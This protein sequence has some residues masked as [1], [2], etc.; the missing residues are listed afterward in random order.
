MKELHQSAVSKQ[1]ANDD[2]CK[3][4]NDLRVSHYLS[5]FLSNIS[6]TLFFLSQNKTH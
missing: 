6:V 5:M 3:I 4:R 1:K 2:A